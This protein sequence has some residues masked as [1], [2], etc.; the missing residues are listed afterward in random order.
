MF[1]QSLGTT[2]SG[3][4]SGNLHSK[5][6]LETTYSKSTVPIKRNE[7][8]R[9]V[10][11]KRG[12][13]VEESV[14]SAS[15]TVIPSPRVSRSQSTA[16][17]SSS[18]SESSRSKDNSDPKDATPEATRNALNRKSLRK[19]SDLSQDCD[20]DSLETPKPGNV[21]SPPADSS[22]ITKDRLN[23]SDKDMFENS[24]SSDVK[25]AEGQSYMM[26]IYE[27]VKGLFGSSS[28]KRGEAFLLLTFLR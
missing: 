9:R 20:R 3:T 4:F 8:E 28:K 19:I 5:S 12:K 13:I 16:R 10:W 22:C 11:N 2:R 6:P 15:K 21:A 23:S 7:Q 26:S 27:K 24:S 18:E 17:N 14:K 25:P 1:S